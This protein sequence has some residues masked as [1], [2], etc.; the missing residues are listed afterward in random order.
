MTSKHEI[1]KSWKQ[2][3]AQTNTINSG[4]YT[5][6]ISSRTLSGRQQTLSKI[7]TVQEKRQYSKQLDN[8][9]TRNQEILK[10]RE[11][12]NKKRQ[13]WTTENKFQVEHS[14]VGEQ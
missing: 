14:P 4:L 8:Q 7:S 2:E 1:R 13:P 10:T 6:E 5:V 12:A 3:N 11:R 9:Q